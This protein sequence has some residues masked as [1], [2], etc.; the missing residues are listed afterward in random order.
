[1]NNPTLNVSRKTQDCPFEAGAIWL[2]ALNERL[3]AEALAAGRPGLAETIR[4]LAAADAAW[5]AEFRAQR[6]PPA[7]DLER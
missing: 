6:A 5:L 1:M 7:E 4:E 2:A 3:I